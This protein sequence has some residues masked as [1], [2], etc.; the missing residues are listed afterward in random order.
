MLTSDEWDSVLPG[1]STKYPPTF[2]CVI[3]Q[4]LA[5]LTFHYSWLKSNL[6]ANHP[7]FLSLVWSSGILPRLSEKVEAGVVENSSSK[8][9]ATGVPQNVYL[10]HEMKSLKNLVKGIEASIVSKIDEFPHIIE[11]QIRQQMFENGEKAVSANHL[12]KSLSELEDRLFNRLSNLD[13]QAGNMS[14]VESTSDQEVALTFDRNTPVHKLCCPPGKVFDLWN[15]WWV[16]NQNMQ[17]PPL[18]TC[19]S[20]DFQSRR[21]QGNFAKVKTVV[22]AIVASSKCPSHEIV[23]MSVPER[24]NLFQEAF[25]EMGR[26]LLGSSDLVKLN[27]LAVAKYHTVYDMIAK[28]KKM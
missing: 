22:G 9:V 17:I 10:L 1:Y 20:R 3:P 15:L 11:N 16:G 4:L 28:S 18:R 14:V 13:Q 5:S 19:N 25:F 6:H 12:N 27:K 2:R 21:D 24:V 26:R 7:L 8:L 23:N